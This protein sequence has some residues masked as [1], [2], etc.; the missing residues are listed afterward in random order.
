MK[1]ETIKIKNFRNFE[2]VEIPLSNKNVFFGLNDIGKTNFLFALR[3]LFDNSVRKN[4]FD[5]SDYFQNDTSRE[6]EILVEVKI[7]DEEDDAKLRAVMKE[8]ILSDAKYVRIA[9]KGKYSQQLGE[10]EYY[11]FWGCDTND[12]IPI[13]QYGARSELDKVFHVTY[14]DSFARLETWFKQCALKMMK[15]DSPDDESRRNEITSLKREINE[16]IANLSGVRSMEDLLTS[17]YKHLGDR[18][19]AVK[20]K[21]GLDFS[22]ELSR[23]EPYLAFDDSSNVYPFSGDG[24]RKLLAYTL[25]GIHNES[26]KDKKIPLLLIE[27]PE[28]HLHKSLQIKLS[29]LLFGSDSNHYLFVTTHSPYIVY[30]MDEVNLVRLSNN[31]DKIDGHTHFF[32][33]PEEYKKHKECL[34]YILSE[35]IF[36]DFVLLVEGPSEKILFSRL[37]KSRSQFFESRGLYILPVNG[38]AFEYYY[39]VLKPLNILVYVRTDNDLREIKSKTP[40]V[41]KL[42]TPLGFRRCNKLISKTLLPSNPVAGTSADP[43]ETKRQIFDQNKE[44][45]IRILQEDHISL[46]RVDLENDLADALGLERMAACFTEP[47]SEPI[48]Y[49]QDSK[50]YHM[51]EMV[52]K[53]SSDDYNR[54]LSNDRF[55]FIT[56]I[57]DAIND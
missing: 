23:I 9:I 28:N 24:R 54:I 31:N 10:S 8:A 41:E 46:S 52:Q 17:R 40:C 12:A 29:R 42:Y 39:Q 43:R 44:V 27:E 26:V 1:F 45:I 2:D 57:C 49:L 20:L 16:V 37:I 36:A 38:I 7:D 33:V 21:S 3:F 35:A 5:I 19:L 14:V 34:N 48:K 18:Q 15:T 56:D 11:L 47:Q 53:L 6:I 30:E 25:A 32:S 22:N 13:P 50:M 55:K 4:N 51:A